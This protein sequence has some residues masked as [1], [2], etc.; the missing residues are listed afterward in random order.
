MKRHFIM[1]AAGCSNLETS[2]ELC[3]L[4]KFVVAGSVFRPVQYVLINPRHDNDVIWA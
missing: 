4:K 2:F 1:V 3:G